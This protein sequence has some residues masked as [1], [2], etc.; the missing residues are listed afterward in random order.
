VFLIGK[1]QLNSLAYNLM[2]IDEFVANCT[3]VPREPS[4]PALPKVVAARDMVAQHVSALS[5]N[6]TWCK[7]EYRRAIW[8]IHLP[9]TRRNTRKGRKYT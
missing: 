8:S 9:N 1:I 7:K 3:L 4:L 2:Y 6:R 5:Q